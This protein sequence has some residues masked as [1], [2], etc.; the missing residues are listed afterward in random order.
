MCIA[1]MS[2]VFIESTFAQNLVP[3]PGFELYDSL[4]CNFI[5]YNFEF[6]QCIQ[7][8]FMPTGGTTDI[9]STQIPSTCAYGNPLS[10]QSC[11]LQYPRSGDAMIGMIA[12][13]YSTWNEYAEIQLISPLIPG[14]RYYFECYVLLAYCSNF[15]ANNFGAAVCVNQYFDSTST[16]YINIAPVV[17]DST[18]KNNSAQWEKISGCFAADSAYQYLILGHFQNNCDTSTLFT[19]SCPCSYYFVDDVYLA[20]DSTCELTGTGC[21]TADNISDNHNAELTSYIE[22]GQLKL[23]LKNFKG[24][25]SIFSSIGKKIKGDVSFENST[26]IDIHSLAQGVYIGVLYEDKNGATYPFKFVKN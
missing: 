6:S 18:I 15:T 3:N 9:I 12:Q 5:Q 23:F 11:G 7:D 2:F 4:P 21:L 14:K 1:I 19:G 25:F 13:S 20:E 26:S 24:T 16:D 10:F 22:S 8:W 17:Q